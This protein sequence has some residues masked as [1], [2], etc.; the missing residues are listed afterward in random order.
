MIWGGNFIGIFLGDMWQPLKIG[1]FLH[2]NPPYSEKYDGV[3]EFVSWDVM[4]FPTVS[5]KS[6]TK[7]HGSSHHHPASNL[8]LTIGEFTNLSPPIF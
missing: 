3:S 6:P 8:S 1:G 5:G 2:E 4:T 7:F